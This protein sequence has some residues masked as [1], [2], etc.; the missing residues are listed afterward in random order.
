MALFPCPREDDMAHYYQPG[1]LHQP[2]VPPQMG[3]RLPVTE[4]DYSIYHLGMVT[5]EMRAVRVAKFEVIDS[6]HRFQSD[7]SYLADE[8]GLTVQR[9]PEGRGWK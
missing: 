8:S 6:N 7:Y 1:V 9:I 4:L 3:F 2:W 5:P